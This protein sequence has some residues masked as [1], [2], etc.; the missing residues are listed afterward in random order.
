VWWQQALKVAI[1]AAFVLQ[2][3]VKR[4]RIGDFFSCRDAAAEPPQLE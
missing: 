1:A 4:S 3:Y 2:V